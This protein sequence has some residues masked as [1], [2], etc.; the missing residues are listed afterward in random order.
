[1][2]KTRRWLAVVVGIAVLCGG[3][4]GVYRFRQVRAEDARK[5][6]IAEQAARVAEHAAAVADSD[7][8]T[9]GIRAYFDERRRRSELRNDELALEGAQLRYDI[10][11]LEGR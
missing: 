5:A 8:I 1:M 3:A 6:R 4:A 2:N 7:R 10:A 11:G 9:E